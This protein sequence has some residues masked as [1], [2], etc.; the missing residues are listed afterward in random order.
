MFVLLDGFFWRDGFFVNFLNWNKG[1]SLD[2]MSFFQEE[3]VEM[4]I[5]SGKWNDVIC[6]IKRRYVCK[7]IVR[8]YYIMKESFICVI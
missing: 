1:E 3:C 8:M 4:Y 6:F 7:K 5:D 2:A